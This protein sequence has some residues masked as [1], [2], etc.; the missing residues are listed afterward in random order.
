MRASPPAALGATRASLLLLLIAARAAVPPPLPLL[1]LPTT[2]HGCFNDSA[3]S[4]TFPFMA[5]NGGQSDPFGANATLETCAYLCARAGPAFTA[6]AV[7][8][9]AQCFC[10]D[11]AGLARAA[12]LARPDADCAVP[13]RGNSL[14]ACGGEWRLSAYDFSCAPYT[15]G[16]WADTALPAAARVDD[17]VAR[18]DAAGLVAQLLQNGADVY[19]PGAQLPR[20]LVSQECLAGFD[21]G[22]IY[23][24]PPVPALA[25]SGFPQP[26]NLGNTFDAEL[27]REV[28]SAISDEARA[29]FTHAGRPSLTC[30]SPNLNVA[31]DP[32]W[33]RNLE[34]FGEDPSLIATLGAAY[35]AGLQAGTPADAAAAA[36]GYLKVM[37]VP[38]HLGAYSVE[39]YSP[40]GPCSYP[41]CDVYRASFNAV[42]DE[43]DL[44]ET[45]FPAWAAAVGEA[46]ASGVMCSYNAIDGVPA[47]AD[48]SVLRDALVGEWGLRGFVISDAD[49]VALTGNV[50]NAGPPPTQG[51]NFSRS[52]SAAA[53]GALLNGTTISLEDGDRESAAYAD[54]LLPAVAAGALSLDDLRAAARRALLP[55]FAVGLYDGARVPWAAIPASVIESDAAHALARRAAAASF[56]LLKNDGALPWAPPARGGPRTVAVVGPA[57]N[58]SFVN[59]YSG[60]PARVSTPWEGVRAAAAA[61]GAAAVYGGSALDDAAVAAVAAADAALVVLTG[62][63]EGE[64]RDRFDIG[65]PA[66]QAAF[67][68][69]LLAT[70]TPLVVAV[71]S[72]GAVDV[73]PALGAA[74]VLAIY[75]GGMEAGAALGD[76]LYGAVNPSGALAATMYK[77][78][79]TNASDFLSMAVRAPP[80]RGH[81]YLTPAA[82]AAHVLFPFGFGLSFTAW[83]PS[84][85]A[86]APAAVSAAAL[87]AGANVTVTVRVANTGARAGD[88]AVIAFLARA[89]APPAAEAWPAQWLPRGGFAKLHGVA[90]GAAAEATLALTARDFSRWDAAARAF[91]V[92]PGAYAVTLRDGAPGAA[93]ALVVTQ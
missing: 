50:P 33:G 36:S 25:S 20:Y 6:A 57:A 31:R 62:S 68:A 38:K 54:E 34:S 49:A 70:R 92:R 84:V 59:R 39:S 82:A 69:R 44:R 17:L 46:N 67:L 3:A 15:P 90:A 56:V 13:C 81:R 80:G 47:C 43:L 58:S 28:A 55:R 86:L 40:R 8:N 93:A 37:A 11:A 23:L 42:V 30:M 18:L 19:A 64:S 72:G 77:A 32:R 73:A 91:V 10:T 41:N 85:A 88:Y 16:A 83:S 71:A 48:G 12:P 79:W 75:T 66:D 22:N 2:H 87:A 9:G 26:V 29:A 53:V 27:V 14:V 61:A 78:S 60:H 63:G 74:A 24:A 51:H 65:F 89:D 7:E 76:I 52:L 1:C 21:G 5:S 35:V 4:R 45:Y